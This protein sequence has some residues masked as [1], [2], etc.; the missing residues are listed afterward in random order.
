MASPAQPSRQS[1]RW[2]SFL[3]Q[4]VAGVESRLDT[5]LADGDE[6]STKAPASNDTKAEQLSPKAG[7]PTTQASRGGGGLSRTSSASRTHDRLQE[8][9]ARTLVKKDNARRE[10]HDPPSS[11][12]LSSGAGSPARDNQSSRPSVDLLRSDSFDEATDATAQG[13]RAVSTPDL[14]V[15]SEVNASMDMT[16]DD[17]AQSVNL[18]VSALA[19]T[20]DPALSSRPSTDSHLSDPSRPSSES[21]R[22]MG[23]LTNGTIPAAHS[24]EEYEALLAQLGADH[25][26]AELRRQQEMHEYIERIDA[27]Q[28][29]LQYLSR[30][31]VDSART[32]AAVAPPGSLEKKV[33]EKDEQIALLMEEGQ[34]LSKSELKYTTTIKKLRSAAKEEE[35]K[36]QEAQRSSQMSE[37]E[38]ADLRHRLR[39]SEQ[40]EKRLNERL[41]LL[42]K[43]DKEL[44]GVK[45][46]RDSTLSTVSTL[47]SQLAE[48][49]AEAAEAATRAQ[50]GALEAERRLVQDLRDDLSN[51]KIEKELA[52]ERVRAEL[53]AFKE[54]AE[55]EKEQARATEI[56]LRGEQAMLESK[57]EVLRARAEEV[58]MGA[59]GD[60]QAKLLRQIET[61]QTQY[62]VASENWQGIE[63]SLLTRVTNLE[64]DKDELT[65]KES[66]TRRKAREVNVKSKRLE[67]ELETS[68]HQ[69]QSL[70]RDLSECQEQ[71]AKVQRRIDQ[72]ETT[73]KDTR[74]DFARERQGWEYSLSQRID[75]ERAR[76]REEAKSIRTESPS[77]SIRRSPN[78][79]LSVSQ[80]RRPPLQ[81]DTP[82]GS[83][84]R[85]TSR[86]NPPQPT[87]TPEE[88]LPRR[89]NSSSY[90]PQLS[91]GLAIPE[92]PSIHT[93]DQDD[94]FDT[95][96][97]PHRT[98]NDMISGSAT[99]AGPS[100]QLVERMSAA[101]RRLESEKAASKDE[102]SRLSTQR[103][104]ARA[105]VVSLMREV[106][107]KRSADE[108]I[109]TL[110]AEVAQLNERYQTTLEMLGEKSE[111]VD[112]LR[113]DVADVKKIYRELV[114]ST[115][116]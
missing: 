80:A 31:A 82:G 5:I 3:Q 48:S 58:S 114:D 89:Q 113:A 69:V 87:R 29:K 36:R 109:S 21:A 47:Q 44:E 34:K 43:V 52:E 28:A 115:L 17:H 92:T 33:A 20:L 19:N 112:E 101:V 103:D 74:A 57:M 40:A 64:K 100:V 99:G 50:T 83:S 38:T 18:G 22:E 107:E 65:R 60:A 72:A 8:R 15:T 32:A 9:L 25:E 68:N 108:K 66:E 62:A 78:P 94:M 39:L 97:S 70:E 14:K 7:T 79:D 111:L 77:T 4:A 84:E 81:T 13:T 6:A 1:S 91:M 90:M 10:N 104:E 95:R 86:R 27:L 56:E 93:V 26:A 59:T 67:D 30:E 37:K 11:P 46:D 53:R 73:L 75:Q 85:P 96:S 2:G 41:K 76:W 42:L 51:A 105:E 12:A 63:A 49:K 24:T 88:D 106:E 61:L 16:A 110:E 116:K 71:L 98:I 35:K 54:K 102:L 23:P 45:A 55:R